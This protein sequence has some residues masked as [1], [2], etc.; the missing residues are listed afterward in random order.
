MILGADDGTNWIGYCP[1]EGWSI[2]EAPFTAVCIEVGR[3]IEQRHP[4]GGEA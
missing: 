1:C 4:R 2:S 3:H